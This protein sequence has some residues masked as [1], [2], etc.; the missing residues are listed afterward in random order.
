MWNNAFDMFNFL[1]TNIPDPFLLEWGILKIRWYGFLMVVGGLFGYWLILK[2]A[3]RKEVEKKIFDDLLIYFP[4]GAIIGA[5]IYYIIYAWDFYKDNLVDVF[6]VWEGGLA[7]HGIIIGGFAA[8]YIYCRNKKISFW[9]IADLAAVGL[10]AAQMIGRAGNYFNQEIFG[11]PTESAWGIPIELANRPA[12][13]ESYSFFHPVFIYECLGSAVIAS[14]LFY[15]NWKKLKWKDGT[16]FLLYL[17]LYSA[18]RFCL[19]F[20]RIDYS[21]TIFGFRWAMIMSVLIF[22]GS[23]TVFIWKKYKK[24]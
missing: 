5:R 16:V 10:S 15:L 13:Y 24:A 3:K 12:G 17:M 7:V 14:L 2:L 22:C 20:L 1:H 9:R 23:L 18:M 8:T 6:K 11:K 21:P 4:L 19:E